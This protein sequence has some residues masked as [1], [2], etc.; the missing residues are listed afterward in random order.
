[1]PAAAGTQD[2]QDAVERAAEVTS[3]SANVR[4][5]W[6]EVFLDNILQIVVDFLEGHNPVFYLKCLIILGQP[7][8]N[9]APNRQL[10]D[11][12]PELNE[13]GLHQAIL[14]DLFWS[15]YEISTWHVTV[16]NER[17]LRRLQ[18]TQPFALT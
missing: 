11:N 14:L 4:L 13:K 9:T 6:W 12:R 7:R 8:Q 5:C 18:Y 1:M 16:M 10:T 2:V 15:R 17:I 3:R